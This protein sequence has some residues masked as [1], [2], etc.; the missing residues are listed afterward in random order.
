MAQEVVAIVAADLEN[1]IGNLNAIPW[2]LG[3]DMQLFRERTISHS[4]VMGRATYESLPPR[5]R[6]LPNR[7][8]IVLTRNKQ[9]EAPGTIV[10]H[11][12]PAVLAAVSGTLYVAGGAQVY[13]AFLPHLDKILLTRVHTKVPGDTKLPFYPESLAEFALMNETAV[14]QSTKDEFSCT[15]KEYHRR[16]L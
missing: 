11:S 16:T 8:N 15:I 10:L 2:R 9:Y 14:P 4:V 6:P 3:T 5:Y 13:Q 12:V 7:E 1:T